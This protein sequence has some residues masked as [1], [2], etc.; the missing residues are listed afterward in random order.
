MP[1]R[2]CIYCRTEATL[3]LYLRRL[4]C[5]LYCVSLSVL[6]ATVQLIKHSLNVNCRFY[7]LYFDKVIICLL[8]AAPWVPCDPVI[9]DTEQRDAGLDNNIKT[10]RSFEYVLYFLGIKTIPSVHK[11]SWG[12]KN[13][14]THSNVLNFRCHVELSPP[15]GKNYI[16]MP[17]PARLLKFL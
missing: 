11:K 14:S 4:L 10:T 13:Y 15:F 6:T 12:N 7:V 16:Q 5:Y 3:S 17:F 1:L 9:D 8:L 2:L